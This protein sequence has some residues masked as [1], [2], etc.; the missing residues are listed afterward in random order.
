MDPDKEKKQTVFKEDDT[1]DV[2][3][4]VHKNEDETSI[5]L[6]QNI[7]GLLCYLFGF[8]TGIIFLIVEKDNKFVKFH[9]F[10]S[11][12][13]FTFLFVLAFVFTRIPF[14]GWLIGLSLT[15]FYFLVWIF[16]M[17]KA[18]KNEMFKLPVV[19]DLAEK[20]L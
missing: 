13:V 12:I 15:P 18:Y 10:Q 8:I 17:Y 11:T 14:I 2:E 3:I 20:Q 9:A 6:D 5:G 19:G 4:K 16:L 7:T 1:T